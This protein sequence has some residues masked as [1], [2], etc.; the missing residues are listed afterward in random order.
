MSAN[1]K[2]ELVAKILQ[3]T[4]K[5]WQYQSTIIESVDVPASE[6]GKYLPWLV[7]SGLVNYSRVTD[8]YRTSETG[9]LFL[10]KYD[11]LSRFIHVMIRQ[12]SDQCERSDQ[13][14]QANIQTPM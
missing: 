9:L 1:C 8:L 5:G 14:Q 10:S 7:E 2:I 13:T 6:T 11:E 3:S 12:Q 4:S